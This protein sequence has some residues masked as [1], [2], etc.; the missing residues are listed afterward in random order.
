MIFKYEIPDVPPSNNKFIGRNQR[1]QYQDEKKKWTEA[2]A[3]FCRPKPKVPFKRAVVTLTYHFKDG[4]RRD[5]DNYSGKFILD[6]LVRCGILAD[7]SFDV[8]DLKLCK[9]ETSKKPYTEIEV[10]E[11]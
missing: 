10:E 2:V 7:D 5:P 9:G 3:L 6:G 1:W 8:I 11:K 4:R